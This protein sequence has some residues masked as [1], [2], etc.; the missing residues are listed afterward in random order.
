MKILNSKRIN[1]HKYC[2]TMEV[3]DKDVELFED[4]AHA[5]VVQGAYSKEKAK[6]FSEYEL[7]PRI[8]KQCKWWYSQ[9]WKYCWRLYD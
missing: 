6:N 1:K 4:L 3:T 5:Y 8:Q 9:L 7:L 2:I